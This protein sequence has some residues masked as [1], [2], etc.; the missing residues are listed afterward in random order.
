LWARFYQTNASNGTP[1]MYTRNG[2][3]YWTRQ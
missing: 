3:Y 1:G 2:N